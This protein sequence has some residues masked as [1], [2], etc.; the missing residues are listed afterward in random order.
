MKFSAVILAGG[1]SSRMGR[2]KAWLEVDGQ[3]LLARQLKLV[4]KAGASEIFISGRSDVDY[5]TFGLRVLRDQFQNAG[6]LAGI[7][8]ALAES[9]SQLLLVLAV[10]MPNI[11]AEF[12]MHLATRCT[13]HCG[14][15]P[16]IEGQIE[17]L[18]A[19]YPKL[20]NTIAVNL[21]KDGQ[22]AANHFA[23]CCV[24]D[25]LATFVELPAH[26]ARLFENWNAPNDLPKGPQ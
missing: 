16:R 5:S 17:P 11:T 3:T 2:D 18:A 10:D 20:A 24:S 8:S 25:N 12:L 14:A 19:L 15:I 4:R 1:E 6:P 22:N 9:S 7:E 26:D 13:E 21:L 23:K